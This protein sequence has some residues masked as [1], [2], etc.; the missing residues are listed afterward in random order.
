M[1]QSQHSRRSDR[2][3]YQPDD[4]YSRQPTRYQRQ[5]PSAYEDWYRPQ[6]RTAHAPAVES[7]A[8]RRP[9]RSRGPEMTAAGMFWYVLG[10]IAMGGMYFAKVPCKKALEQAGL[11][12]MTSAERFWYVLG[13]LPFGAFYFCKLPVLKALTEVNAR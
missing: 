12:T 7:P 3:R 1:H 9:D 8:T 13:C 5:Q 4:G 11:G 2:G 6:E 10:C